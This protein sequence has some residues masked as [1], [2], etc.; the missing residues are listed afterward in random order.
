[1]PIDA[2]TRERLESEFDDQLDSYI[3]EWSNALDEHLAQADAIRREPDL[4]TE[5]PQPE[6]TVEGL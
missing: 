5:P 3:E 6:K 4:P 2:E 1:M